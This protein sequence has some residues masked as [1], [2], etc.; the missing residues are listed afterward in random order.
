M[1]KNSLLATCI[2]LRYEVDGRINTER[3]WLPVGVV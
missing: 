3:R 1:Q 2:G